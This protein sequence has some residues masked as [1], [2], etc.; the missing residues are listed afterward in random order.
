M[1]SVKI[2][3]GAG[4]LLLQWLNACGVPAYR[5]RAIPPVMDTGSNPLSGH[6]LLDSQVDNLVSAMASFLPPSSGQTTLPQSYQDALG[7]VIA[8][9]WS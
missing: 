7:S 5:F 8:A 6:T 4:L 1:G 2:L 3:A 9:N